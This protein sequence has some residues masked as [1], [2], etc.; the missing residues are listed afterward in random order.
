MHTDLHII[1]L[2]LHSGTL[3]AC[4]DECTRWMQGSDPTPPIKTAE[5]QHL[6]KPREKMSV[7]ARDLTG[8]GPLM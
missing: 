5:D 2:S 1:Q 4:L 7:Q 3:L 8:V 6:E